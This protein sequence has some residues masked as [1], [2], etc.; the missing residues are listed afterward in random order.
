MN[1]WVSR[2]PMAPASARAGGGGGAARGLVA[3]LLRDGVD[4]EGEVSVGAD[5]ALEELDDDLFV[6]GAED[7]LAVALVGEAKEDI[8]HGLVAA[9][10]LP[11]FDGVHGGHHELLA[12]KD[13]LFR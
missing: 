10:C 2:P 4:E 7:E 6:G 9:G 1:S 12:M 13:I 5:V 3:E 11:D 8:L